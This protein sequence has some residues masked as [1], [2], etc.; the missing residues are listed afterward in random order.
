MAQALAPSKIED[1]S[2]TSSDGESSLFVRRFWRGKPR[3]QFIILHGALEHSGRLKDLVDF[4]MKSYHDVSV[5]VF[6]HIGHGR[7][8]GARAYVPEFK[9][10]VKDMLTVGEF[11]QEHVG[12][13][14][15][16]F[17]C[18]HSLGGLITL[19]RLLDS[20]YG[21]NLPLSGV[22]LSSP[23]IKPKNALG[24]NTDSLVEK[25][26]KFFPRLHIPMIYKG[27]DLSR[28]VDRANDFDTDSLIPRFITVRMIKQILEASTRIRGLSY[29]LKFPSLFLVSGSDCLVEPESTV[30]FAH[31][32]DKKLSTIIQYPEHRHELWNE[33]DR[34]EIFLTM[35]QWVDKQLKEKP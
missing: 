15:R 6:D 2:L 31:G 29:Y 30:L 18:A 23:C 19:T 20:T 28:D 3:I 35:R 32:I 11:A 33:S 21:W 17:I 22:I 27:S 9:T 1:R 4:W 7:S 14:C 24:V 25:L 26:D 16:N 34:Q 12:E 5:V 13:E 8:G 10:Y